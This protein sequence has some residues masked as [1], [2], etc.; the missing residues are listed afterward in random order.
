MH[1]RFA[2]QRHRSL[3]ASMVRSVA[4]SPGLANA[5]QFDAS[6]E[7]DD[8]DDDDDDIMDDKNER[9]TAGLDV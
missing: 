7:D 1:V 2:S 3:A 8:D 4:E 5:M 9:G 6:T